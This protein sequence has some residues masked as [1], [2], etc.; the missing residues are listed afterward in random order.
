MNKD[1]LA[2]TTYHH[3]RCSQMKN[4]GR[5]LLVIVIG[6]F[7]LTYAGHA[8]SAAPVKVRR[9]NDFYG[10]R[11]QQQGTADGPERNV[12]ASITACPWRQER[13]ELIKH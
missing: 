12:A 3:S 5:S 11:K 10:N 8:H 9:E 13:I 2:D 4:H 1:T 6:A 7:G